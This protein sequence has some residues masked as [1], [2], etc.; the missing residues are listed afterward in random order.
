M[1]GLM[2]W[3][4]GGQVVAGLGI[5]LT[6]CSPEDT[7]TLP[8]PGLDAGGVPVDGRD[9][10]A[11]NTTSGAGASNGSGSVGSTGTG[12][13]SGVASGSAGSG[14]G[15]GA[16]TGA[17]TGGSMGV[18][19]VDG[20]SG[21]TSGT[22][23]GSASSDGSARGATG[24]SGASTGGAALDGGMDA[25][26]GTR[27]D[28]A[29][30]ATAPTVPYSTKIAPILDPT[31]RDACHGGCGGLTIAYANI[32]GVKSGEVPTV[33]Y[34][35]PGDPGHSYLWCK[36]NPA[37]ADCASARTVI[38]GA[39]MPAD[40]PPYLSATNLSLIKTWILQGAPN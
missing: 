29:V 33:N 25:A 35:N 8:P 19:A 32:V 9:S 18:D 38:M 37:D 21:S 39:R 15:S 4:L 11:A 31:C 36:V 34:I 27:G 28:A 6:A 10:A 17:A 26:G 13:G 40:G 5:V 20:G 14:S 7:G 16:S 30:E 22:S 23:N 2:R 12:T 24:G 1:I 3:P